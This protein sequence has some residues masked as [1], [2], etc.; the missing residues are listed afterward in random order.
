MK[1]KAFVTVFLVF[2]MLFS[3]DAFGQRG[4]RVPDVRPQQRAAQVG[5]DVVRQQRMLTAECIIPELTEEQQSQIKALRIK[6]LEAATQHRNQMDELRAK[7]RTMMTQATPDQRDLERTIDQMTSLQNAQMK[8]NIQHRQ[9][10][11]N[12]LTEEQR[13]IFDS[14]TMRAQAGRSSMQGRHPAMR[15]TAPQQG[16][17]RW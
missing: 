8:E 15:G 16:R 11:R 2:I 17:G 5:E 3:I 4:R 12:L 1:T 14:R 6:Q 13:V 7:K 9:A 10:I